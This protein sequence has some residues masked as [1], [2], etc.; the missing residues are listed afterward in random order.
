MLVLAPLA[1]NAQE[2]GLRVPSGQYLL[3]YETLWEDH[4]TE[5]KSGETWLILRFLAPDI[6]KSGGKI[7]FAE[8]EPDLLYLC[9]TVGL[10]LAEI[11]GGGV[12]QI[13]VSLLSK[14]IP[15]GARDPSITQFMNAFRVVDGGCT[16]EF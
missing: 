3:P 6:S 1:S 8:A 9:K 7:G 4:L 10:K 16:W 12:D 15:R 11:T 14:P 2:G 13:V 5:G